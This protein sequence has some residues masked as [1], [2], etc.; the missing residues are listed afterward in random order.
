M[1]IDAA[2]TFVKVFRHAL[3]IPQ[4]TVGHLDRLAAA[5]ARLAQSPGLFLAGNAY[6]GVAINSCIAE[7]ARV[8]SQALDASL[9]AQVSGLT[10]RA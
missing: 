7:A 1:G 3:G 9:R 2:P 4:Y 8:A 6:R 5:D 10:A